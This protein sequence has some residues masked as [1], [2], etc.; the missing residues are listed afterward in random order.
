MEYSADLFT[1]VKAMSPDTRY[2]YVLKGA[3]YYV[4]SNGEDDFHMSVNDKESLIE[5]LYFYNH[6]ISKDKYPIYSS[7]Y[8]LVKDSILMNEIFKQ[9][10]GLPFEVMVRQRPNQDPQLLSGEEILS[11]IHF[12]ENLEH[13]YSRPH[14]SPMI[15]SSNHPCVIDAINELVA[16]GFYCLNPERIYNLD[17]LSEGNYYPFYIDVKKMEETFQ[18]EIFNSHKLIMDFVSNPFEITK[19]V[20]FRFFEPL[21]HKTKEE[22]VAIAFDRKVKEDIS[23]GER[24]MRL[25]LRRYF[26]ALVRQVLNRFFMKKY[27]ERGLLGFTVLDHDFEGITFQHRMIYQGQHYDMY[28]SQYR[29][30]EKQGNEIIQIYRPTNY[31]FDQEDKKKLIQAFNTIQSYFIKHR[32][33]MFLP[34]LF[35]KM[36]GLP[37]PAFEIAKYFDYEHG[38]STAFISLFNFKEDISYKRN[39]LILTLLLEDGNQ[40]S[41]K[42]WN[43]PIPY[44]LKYLEKIGLYV[45]NIYAFNNQNFPPFLLTYSGKNK[46]LESIL[47]GDV[48]LYQN[49]LAVFEKQ[50]DF[51]SAGM[52]AQLENIKDFLVRDQVNGTLISIDAFFTSLC[53]GL[54]S[55]EA[56]ER[57]KE[58]IRIDVYTFRVFLNMVFIYCYGE[59]AGR[60]INNL[61]SDSLGR[62]FKN[63]SIGEQFY[64]EWI[65]YPYVYKGRNFIAYSK[66]N[67]NFYF[68]EKDKKAIKNLLKIYDHY[69]AQSFSFPFTL[70]AFGREL[71][72]E[73]TE[74]ELDEMKRAKFLGLPQCVL[75][76]IDLRQE[77]L[78]QLQFK[79]NISLLS[80]DDHK[81]LL[82]KDYSLHYPL[83][84]SEMARQ[85]LYLNG[86]L[87]YPTPIYALKEELNDS[88]K[89][90]L[91]FDFVMIQ[92][93]GLSFNKFI[94]PTV[95]EISSLTPTKFE[96]QFFAPL[97]GETRNDYVSSDD[98]P[99]TIC[100]L[101]YGAD[102][103][104]AYY[105]VIYHEFFHNSEYHH[106]LLSCFENDYYLSL[107]HNFY[108][109]SLQNIVSSFA[110]LEEDKQPFLDAY[111]F[112]LNNFMTIRKK[113]ER[114]RLITYHL[115]LPVALVC[116][117]YH[118]ILQKD[119]K[120]IDE[121]VPTLSHFV[122]EAKP[123][124]SYDGILAMHEPKSTDYFSS[125]ELYHQALLEG[126][127]VYPDSQLIFPALLNPKTMADEID[128]IADLISTQYVA[129]LPNQKD[130]VKSLLHP[131]E[132]LFNYMV[133][134]FIQSY[135]EITNLYSDLLFYV[136]EMLIY[137]YHK[138]KDFIIQS[139]NTLQGGHPE[140]YILYLK[141]CFK[142]FELKEFKFKYASSL[143]YRF[144]TF[145]FLYI[146]QQILYRISKKIR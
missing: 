52:L 85:G 94:T 22:L 103:M 81:A 123:R 145:F 3:F 84:F 134:D 21:D 88:L 19:D 125:T 115:G 17:H 26:L 136:Q 41:M 20:Y 39:G 102:L 46:K 73:Y 32:E 98:D 2:R 58:K 92:L 14:L 71:H 141:K 5:R 43:S 29:C 83:I 95:K 37:Y 75:N 51:S 48:T 122:V 99:M 10:L 28:A 57:I 23:D 111:Q 27:H 1:S 9:V 62:L 12:E 35:L 38:N 11:R 146:Q 86:R 65:D 33:Y 144:I 76:Q 69:F 42:Y 126:F 104:H 50:I 77:I 6:Y 129:V 70:H 142:S 91:S 68:D 138:D 113:E 18:G 114:A 8:G 15:L 79:R 119:F 121:D 55:N 30:F 78:P 31:V 131:N 67:K 100:A 87:N 44:Y 80:Y 106:Y 56:F 13:G 139:I 7:K 120:L 53:E 118:K 101:N 72:Y 116:S 36:M 93:T 34:S 137:G 124:L 63:L 90:Y 107:G 108:A 127:F 4:F 132:I 49:A 47:H 110:L 64:D 97:Y 117:I 133:K 130:V 25:A 61:M 54:D 140:E 16:K 128:K 143:I 82:A 66:D 109:Y 89:Y 105:Q 112:V 96:K 60:Q 135:D 24:E 59:P 45:S 74:I 40:L